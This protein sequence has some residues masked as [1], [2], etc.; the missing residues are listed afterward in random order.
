MSTA[1]LTTKRMT[2]EEFAEWASRPE[3]DNKWFELVRGEVIEL[4]A[5]MKR[6]GVVA[7]NVVRALDAYICQR[8]KGYL[9]I[10]DSGVILERDPDTVRGPDVA[11]YEDAQSFN[12]LHPKYGEVPPILA[13]EVLSPSDRADRTLRK[14]TDYLR[15]GV[16]LVW[17][18]DPETRTVT[19]YPADNGPRL[20]EESEDLDGGIHLPSLRCRVA[21]FFHLP[22]EQLEPRSRSPRT[23]R[24]K[25]KNS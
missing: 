13:V 2:V 5:P 24:R 14:I 17:L 23:P 11:L 10:N 22:G 18:V 25:K 7:W 1:T 19:V 21:D 4:P 16:A 15:Y 9:T 6:H 20:V 12:E 3:N 8:H